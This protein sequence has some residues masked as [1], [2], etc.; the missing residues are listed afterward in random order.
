MLVGSRSE[1]SRAT[2]EPYAGRKG[3]PG[4]RLDRRASEP[5]PFVMPRRLAG[6]RGRCNHPIARRNL[7][8][9]ELALREMGTPSLLVALDY[10]DLLAS[11]EHLKT[12]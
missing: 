5:T 11:S 4:P 1:F 12:Q 6:A 9:A 8:R 7:F 2:C 3:S 10:L